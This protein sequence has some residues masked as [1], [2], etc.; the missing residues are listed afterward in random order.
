MEPGVRGI[1]GTQWYY[2]DETPVSP[3]LNAKLVHWLKHGSSHL[4]H[5]GITYVFPAMLYE[6]TFS[7]FIT[8]IPTI[9]TYYHVVMV[10]DGEVMD[11]FV[12][13]DEDM[14]LSG[15]S[16]HAALPPRINYAGF[17]QIESANMYEWLMVD[18][19]DRHDVR[20]RETLM[21]QYNPRSPYL[22]KAKYMGYPDIIEII[23]YALKGDQIIGGNP[24]IQVPRWYDRNDRLLLIEKC[25]ELEESAEPKHI[26]E[27]KVWVGPYYRDST[28][29]PQLEDYDRSENVRLWQWSYGREYGTFDVET[30]RR[31]STWLSSGKDDVVYHEY[32]FHHPGGGGLGHEFTIET[33]DGRGIV[34]EYEEPVQRDIVKFE[35][36]SNWIFTRTSKPF[37]GYKKLNEWIQNGDGDIVV[38]HMT[39][40]YPAKILIGAGNNFKACAIETGGG[41]IYSTLSIPRL[42]IGTTTDRR[43]NYEWENGIFTMEESYSIN[44][45]K[46]GNQFKHQIYF[47]RKS[48]EIFVLNYHDKSGIYYPPNGG[49]SVKIEITRSKFKRAKCLVCA[50]VAT[51]MC[52][53]CE[54]SVCG[55]ECWKCKCLIGKKK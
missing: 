45:W 53:T 17:T 31:I 5:G 21:L 27:G 9:D 11:N 30:C 20:I 7:H 25:K 13:T 52:S 43:I 4:I 12:W 8:G 6:D 42:E 44:Q 49:N 34:T 46:E 40:K 14:E 16:A 3:V 37:I 38:S 41:V 39:L 24:P 36:T 15:N 2:S 29:L 51:L 50:N 33:E 1:A 54:M 10:K 19:T 23:G 35:P 55:E 22:I 18:I 26:S 28:K 32:V 47:E 48:G